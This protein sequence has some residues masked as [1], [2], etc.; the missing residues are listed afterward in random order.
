MFVQLRIHQLWSQTNE[1]HRLE[2]SESSFWFINISY[3]SCFPIIH[4]TKQL[5]VFAL[6]SNIVDLINMLTIL[7]YQFLECNILDSCKFD[8]SCK[9]TICGTGLNI[10]CDH[11]ITAIPF[12]M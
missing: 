1:M 6:N 3:I 9:H 7:G 10:R 2:F 4:S 5:H 12:L 8:L 11:L